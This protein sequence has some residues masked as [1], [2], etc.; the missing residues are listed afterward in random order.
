MVIERR[1]IQE[2]FEKTIEFINSLTFAQ[3]TQNNVIQESLKTTHSGVFI[4]F[5]WILKLRENSLSNPWL[6]EIA[7]TLIQLL[8]VFA[9]A[10][11]KISY[12]LF[13]N[14]IDNFV[15]HLVVV[16]RIPLGQTTDDNFHNLLILEESSVF[17]RL[18]HQ[19]QTVYKECCGYVHS[20][21]EKYFSLY[22]SV[23]DYVKRAHVAPNLPSCANDLN[24][25]IKSIICL[26]ILTNKELYENLDHEDKALVNIYCNRNDLRDI[27]HEF[28][29]HT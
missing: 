21:D 13:R 12:M 11:I 4:Y 27:Y 22:E 24:R 8:F 2:D 25:L 16:K 3:F 10:D 17:R 1:I 26:L 29:Y 9:L 20:T 19:L 23:L 28:Y 15:K 18:I 6:E 7:S 5:I 14:I